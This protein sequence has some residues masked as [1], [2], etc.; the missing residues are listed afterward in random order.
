[1]SIIS[2]MRPYFDSCPHGQTITLYIPA[3]KNKVTLN[4]TWHAHDITGQKL[5]IK[6]NFVITNGI[7]TFEWWAN[8]EEGKQRVMMEATDRWGHTVTCQ[9]Y[10]KVLG[11]YIYSTG[12]SE[13]EH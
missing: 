7:I 1:M 2:G 12:V 9:F 6:S 8:G 3:F 11:R 5:Q 13:V 10:V 4:V